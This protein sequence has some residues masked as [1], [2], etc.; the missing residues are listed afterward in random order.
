MLGV[1]ILAAGQGTRM[2]SPLPK[3][4]HEAAGKPLLTH[5]LAAVAP[6]EPDHTV[7]IV[8]HAAAAVEA[9]FKDYRLNGRPI[10][11]VRQDFSQGYGTGRALK[12]AEAVFA[13]FEG[14]IMV[15][16]GDV[17]LVRTET[18]RTLVRTQ[19]AQN[20][21][22]TFLTCVMRNPHGMGRI[23][24]EDDG[25]VARIV[26]EK[27]LAA[28]EKAVRE[29]NPALYIFDRHVFELA[30]E[31]KNDNAAGEYYITDLV[32]LYLRAHYP[33]QTVLGEDETEILGVNDQE[34]LAQVDR[35]LRARGSGENRQGS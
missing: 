24:R 23:I 12:Q 1:V 16:S 28:E 25:N 5:V 11:F 22:M 32:D 20:D 14:N 15:L 3:V 29:I 26:E 21:G 2:R 10:S 19:A 9:Q 18:L 4:L 35:L 33:V 34:Q 8:G 31:L 27:D 17:P 7:V 13:E 6:L 30:A